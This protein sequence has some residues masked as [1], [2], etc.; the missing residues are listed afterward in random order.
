MIPSPNIWNDPDVYEIENRGVDPE[1]LIEAAMAGIHDW[2][3]Q[4]VL[5]VGCGSGFHL[6]RF[7]LSAAAVVGV[8]PY[9]P[10]ASLAR[11]RIWDHSL[12]NARVLDGAA[13][14]LPLTNGS[15]DVVHAR[16]AYFFGAGS[17]PGI[18]EA[19]RVL[20]AGGTAFVIDNDASRSTF[21]TWFRRAMPAYD[22]VAVER[23]WARQGW[24]R[25]RIDMQ[26]LFGSRA[27]FESVV[28]IEFA[29]PVADGI[30]AE[31]EGQGVDYAVNLWWRT[32]D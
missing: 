3:G 1:G 22:P 8:E 10:L 4:R 23:F 6:P 21:G 12:T 27:D 19:A 18:A 17:E 31:H 11:Q 16:W 26:W 15:M 20:R 7:A 30:L 29:Q 13:E 2:S 9:Q 14:D 28:R 32:F 24:S 5:D 25:Q